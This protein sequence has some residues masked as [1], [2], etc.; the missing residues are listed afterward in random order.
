MTGL[1]ELILILILLSNFILLGVF[2]PKILVILLALQG[3]FLGLLSPAMEF[4]G[5]VH[6]VPWRTVYFALA[7]I[8]MKGL[9]F[10]LILSNTIR[11]T[12]DTNYYQ[13]LTGPLVSIL[14]GIAAFI[15]C[16]FFFARHPINPELLKLC[17]PI[18]ALT[19]F[20]GLFLLSMRTNAISQI[21]GYI[22]L[23]NGIYL[24]GIFLVGDIPYLVESFVLLDLLAAVIIKTVAVR[25]IRHEL[26]GTGIH[27]MNALKG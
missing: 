12:R 9:V 21:V 22:T 25:Y 17:F 2:R 18:A 13:P 1:F 3:F 23:E 14:A 15:V 16:M 26:H 27:Q 11:Q 24:C 8:I 19:A 20:T 10:P 7:L 6:E 5:Q 4:S